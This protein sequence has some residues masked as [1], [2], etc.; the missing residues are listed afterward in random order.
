MGP[1]RGPRDGHPPEHRLPPAHGP[2]LLGPGRAP[3][4]P[5]DRPAPVDGLPALRRRGRRPLPVPD[6]RAHRARAATWP[7]S[8]SCSPPTCSSTRG[9]SRS[10][11]CR[12][13]ACPGWWPSSSWPCGGGAGGTRPCSPWWWPWSAASTPARSSSWASPRPCGSPTPS[14]VAREATWRRAWGVAW[15]VGL[16]SALVSL[17]WA[18]GLQVEAAY[19]V[20]VLKYTETV[21][22]TSGASL[23]SEII[24]GLGYWYF[25]GTD[26]VGPW[27]QAAVA[28]T[29]NLWLIGAS[30]AVPVL[31][32]IAAVFSRWRYRA[33]FVLIT[34][35][36]MVLA[37]GPNPYA[38]PSAVGS[39]I[40]SFLVDTTAGLAL[41][42]TDRASPAG[43]PRPGHVP[44]G[45]GQ[46]RGRPGA[47]HRAGHRRRSP[48]PPWPGPPRPCGPG[49]SSPT[50]SPSRRP[51]RSTCAR[52]PPPWTTST[53]GHPGLRPARQQLRR[54]PVG[55]HHR[56]RLPRADDPALRDPRAADH[57]LAGHRRRPPGGG[58]PAP[59]RHHGLE[60]AGPD[61]LADERRGRAGPVRP[62]LRALRH[63]PTPSR[64]PL[65]LATTPPGLTDP[66]SYGAPRPNV[67]LIPHFDEAALARPPNQG[68]PSPLVSYT[69][70]DPRPDRPDRV[71][72]HPAGGR[73]RRHGH[74]ERR[75]GRAAGRQP[76]HPLRRH[77]GHRPGAA[78]GHAGLAGR[79]G[80]HRH[81]PQA[82]PSSGT[83]SRENTGY[84]E[85]AAQGPDTV[86]PDRRP[87]QPV[88]QGPGRRPDHRGAATASPRSPPRPTGPRS[89]TCPRTGPPTPSTATPRPAWVDDSFAAAQ[90]QWWQVV[91]DHPRTESSLTL[92]QPQTGDP[93]RSI[94]RVTLT[95]DGGHP[96]S[97]APR[98]RRR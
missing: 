14:L 57:G 59:G 68:W 30:F 33:Y 69:V 43:H 38:D 82:G 86:Q 95:F 42:S 81:Q 35:V 62:G 26:R 51:P 83:P 17:W 92:V 91:L 28:Y 96:V 64:W 74:R 18:V 21:P 56:H 29:Q 90:G 77:P 9:A 70:A 34:V 53:P 61:G 80:G 85:T 63:R 32:F 27:T 58:H 45:R 3:R 5:V 40:K 94:T 76:D 11:C 36:G 20:N 24:R 2:L 10:S 87:A 47:P 39:V 31:C 97:V 98:R 16:L 54:L 46:R 50:A 48:W 49:P 72:Q 19:G 60:R 52:R 6:H 23:A 84:T 8:P 37:V 73:R 75:L 79:P 41:R 1:G 25:Y 7:P 89:P 71:D 15:K 13:R 78:E 88:P 12:G 66:V 93:D 44:R 4:A 55:R 22:A 67:P 65:D